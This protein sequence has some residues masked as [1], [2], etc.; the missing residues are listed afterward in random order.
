MFD[1]KEGDAWYSRNENQDRTKTS[2]RLIEVLKGKDIKTLLDMGCSDGLFLSQAVKRLGL[3]SEDMYGID[4]SGEAIK[5]G[6]DLYPKINL[7]QSESHA[8]PFSDNFFD[9]VTCSFVLHWIS[10]EKLLRTIAEIDR[11]VRKA[12]Y[13]V[14]HDFYA[15][16]PTKTDYHHR[17]GIF[18]YKQFYHHI[19]TSTALYKKIFF[20]KEKHENHQS[21]IS[22]I[23]KEQ[24]YDYEVYN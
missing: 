5:A 4:I 16:K 8:L 11:V 15:E 12:G 21:Y 18:T 14:I 22:V 10:R 2:Q 19:F 9:A 3:N 17:E 6:R 24:S 1:T 7:N 20:N 23:R 13:I